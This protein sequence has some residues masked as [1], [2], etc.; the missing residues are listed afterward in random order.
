MT[1]ELKA[2]VP[3]KRSYAALAKGLRTAWEA[4][5]PSVDGKLWYRPCSTTLKDGRT[6]PSVYVM[7]DAFLSD[8]RMSFIV[9]ASPVW[10]IAC[11]PSSFQ[12]AANRHV[13]A[14]TQSTL[15]IC[16]LEERT[17]TSARFC[18]MRAGTCLKSKAPNIFGAFSE[19]AKVALALKGSPNNLN[20]GHQT[21]RSFDI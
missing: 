20:V 9:Q 21:W 3:G 4:I 8:S 2:Y 17:Q 7:D 15:F 14:G 18:H 12:M 5:T 1:Q 19:K 16:P 11:S 10:D 13:S 6:L